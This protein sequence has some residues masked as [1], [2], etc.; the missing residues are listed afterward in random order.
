MESSSMTVH[1]KE[2]A[3][4][5]PGFSQ[6]IL[7]HYG[8]PRGQKWGGPSLTLGRSGIETGIQE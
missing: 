2:H 5:D 7:T 1:M 8:S 3:E 6:G 4:S